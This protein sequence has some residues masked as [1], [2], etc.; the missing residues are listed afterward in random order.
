MIRR[1]L[2][3]SIAL[4]AVL[5]LV[6][7][8]LAY[9]ALTPDDK[10]TACVSPEGFVRSANYKDRCPYKTSPVL[11][12]RSG[13]SS[14]DGG[15][16]EVVASEDPADRTIRTEVEAGST[17]GQMKL[18]DPFTFTLASD[19]F[20]HFLGTWKFKSEV[21]G[22]CRDGGPELGA[23]RLVIAPGSSAPNTN[24]DDDSYIGFAGPSQQR[25]VEAG[26]Y[27]GQYFLGEPNECPV[28][29]TPTGTVTVKEVHLRL[30]VDSLTP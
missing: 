7:G 10:V 30:L 29:R 16:H 2:A 12:E 17:E 18:S 9:A 26:T 1:H 14:G 15:G 4:T 11:L 13:S 19:G 20:Y 6:A 23:G 28:N 21:R 27:T 3:L 24:S 25:W 5:S 8:S 22:T